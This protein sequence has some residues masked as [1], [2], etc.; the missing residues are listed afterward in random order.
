MAFTAT[1]FGCNIGAGSSA[2]SAYTY[3]TEEDV[4]TLVEAPGY[5]SEMK[6]T[7]NVGDFIMTY[8]VTDT[9]HGFYFVSSIPAVGPLLITK[10]VGA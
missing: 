7:L 8:G 5:F 6:T 2:P 10:I 9:Y 1:T 4:Y 3:T